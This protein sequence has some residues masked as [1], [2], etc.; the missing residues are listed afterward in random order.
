MG[1]APPLGFRVMDEVMSEL[2]GGTATPQVQGRGWGWVR[3][4]GRSHE[5]TL[6]VNVGLGDGDDLIKLGTTAP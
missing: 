5:D 1:V 2:S 3:A 4:R 6:L